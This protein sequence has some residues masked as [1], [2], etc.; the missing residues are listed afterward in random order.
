[1]IALVLGIQGVGWEEAFSVAVATTGNIGPGFG[2]AG[3]M[4]SYAGFSDI[5]K[6]TLVAAMWIG[7]LEFVAVLVLFHPDVWRSV[8]LRD[9]PPRGPR[10]ESATRPRAGTPPG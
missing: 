8:R 3:P 4:G 10:P 6:L 9:R 5:T 2:Q 1:V 7:R